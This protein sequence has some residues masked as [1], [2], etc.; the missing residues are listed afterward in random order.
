MITITACIGMFFLASSLF[1]NHDFMFKIGQAEAI[2]GPLRGIETSPTNI[3]G[4]GSLTATTDAM[5]ADGGCESCTLIKYIPGTKGIAGISFKPSTMPNLSGA[6]RIVFFVKGE[7]GGENLKFVALG[8]P[9][10][11]SLPPTVPFTN[12][13]FGV[14]SHKVQL[15]NDWK[16]YQ[17]SFNN[18]SLTGVTDP[19]GI[20]VLAGRNQT[21]PSSSNRPP[22]NDKD[23]NHIVF[24]LKG[25]TI[26]NNQAQNPIPLDTNTTTISTINPVA[27]TTKT[28]TA[29]PTQ[30]TSSS[31]PA[32][33][34]PSSMA[35]RASTL[36]P[37]AAAN[38]TKS[39]SSAAAANTTLPAA[40]NAT[41]TSSAAAANTTLPAAN[42]A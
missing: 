6:T 26:D 27:D 21:A 39:T 10:S 34:T 16:R 36:A 20:I 11:S 37:S 29:N 23:A 41:S 5:T 14:V 33:T 31:I 1:D 18:S 8:K 19:F 13:H 28:L 17:L 42:N 25:V 9:S 24:F 4:D 32:T 40:N 12:L 35:D 7:L 22:L 30:N 2:S 38:N 15:T 3:V